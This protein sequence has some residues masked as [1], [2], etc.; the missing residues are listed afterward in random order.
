MCR[1]L[2]FFLLMSRLS[3][4]A[5]NDLS[6][7][8]GLRWAQIALLVFQTEISDEFVPRESDKDRC[9]ENSRSSLGQ[10]SGRRLYLSSR[11]AAL[12]Q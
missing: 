6:H 1:L 9:I 12:A 11:H 10:P 3:L 8:F 7:S 4:D 5:G 2:V